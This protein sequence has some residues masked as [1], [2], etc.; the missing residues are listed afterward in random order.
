MEGSRS[1]LATK[2]LCCPIGIAEACVPNFS[3][4]SLGLKLFLIITTPRSRRQPDH[5]L[6]KSTLAKQIVSMPQVGLAA[7]MQRD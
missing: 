6:E 3:Y 5:P 7:N 2:V 1:F 4:I